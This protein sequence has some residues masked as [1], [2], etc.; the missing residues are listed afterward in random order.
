MMPPN[1]NG[2]SLKTRGWVLRSLAFVLLALPIGCN[3]LFGIDEGKPGCAT[4]DDCRS[5]E[6]PCKEAIDCANGKCEFKQKASDS[7]VLDDQWN[8]QIHL[9]DKD[10]QVLIKQKADDKPP[11]NFC[12]TFTC[13][14]TGLVEI[15]KEDT[16]YDGPEGTR[17][18]GICK[19]GKWKCVKGEPGG[20]CEFDVLPSAENCETTNID[21]DCDGHVLDP[22]E[23]VYVCVPKETVDCYSYDAATLGKGLCKAGTKICDNWGKGYG[24][25]NGEIGPTPEV[26]D[27]GEVDEN[28][29]GL[30]NENCPAAPPKVI[31]LA[32]GAAHTCALFS[33]G[34]VKCWGLGTLGRLGLG[35]ELTMGDGPDEMGPDLP[36][37]NLGTGVFVEELAAGDAHTCARFANGGVK[38]WGANA[39][40]QLGLGDT[41]ARGDGSGEMGGML[42]YVELGTGRTAKAIAAGS[43]HTC[44]L[45]DDSS[46]KCWGYG[47]FGQLGLGDQNSRGDGSGEMGDLLPAV[48]LDVGRSAIALTAGQYH[49][50][51]LLDDAKVKCWGYNEFGQ[52]GQ[53]DTTSRGGGQPNEVSDMSSIPLGP[54]VLSIDA[55]GGHVCVLLDDAS[56]RCWGYGHFGQLGQGTKYN[57]GDEPGE[58]NG[59]SLSPIDLGGRLVAGVTAGTNHTCAQLQNGQLA[60]FGRSQYGQVGGGNL[61]SIGDAMGQMGGSLAVDLGLDPNQMLTSSV[62]GGDHTCVLIDGDVACFGR[63][64]SGQL[65]LGDTNHRGDQLGEMGTMLPRVTLW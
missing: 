32:A 41:D 23:C 52:L 38:C 42:P 46:V 12:T 54:D 4:R 16:C 9:C 59:L 24:A 65:G 19:D 40:G 53:D 20:T 60:C 37:L 25:C 55:G 56:S 33:S 5:E 35:N 62:A 31:A 30:S 39:F 58:I 50:C 47:Y 43:V 64:D 57:L 21:E 22:D 27:K 36:V 45:L 2:V 8:C 17:H 6:T 28:C 61:F 13:K 49:T 1:A 44:V 51:A 11:D 15:P 14:D 29:N 18:K 63:N 10:G 3:A 7:P 48:A 26:C 34:E